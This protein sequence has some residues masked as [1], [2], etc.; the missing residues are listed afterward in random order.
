MGQCVGAMRDWTAGGAERARME[1]RM[2]RR[3]ALVIVGCLAALAACSSG[4]SHTTSSQPATTSTTR[5]VPATKDT[6]VWL[7][8]PDEPGDPCLSS[9]TTT[10]IGPEGTQIVQQN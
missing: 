5:A 6:Q 2:R 8:R 10:V 7:C 9:L 1:D 4:S 3:I